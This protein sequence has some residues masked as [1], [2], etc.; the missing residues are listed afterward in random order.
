MNNALW[1]DVIHWVRLHAYNV[2]AHLRLVVPRAQPAPGATD[3]W[4]G[5][6]P[7]VCF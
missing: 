2:A 4:K 3:R 1:L 6:A 5:Q 7:R